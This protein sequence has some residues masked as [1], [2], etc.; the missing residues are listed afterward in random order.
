MKI[1]PHKLLILMPFVA[2]SAVAVEPPPLANNPFD[3][4]PSEVV[5]SSAAPASVPG[6]QGRPLDLRSTLV[7]AGIML[8]DVGGRVLAPGDSLGDF[9]LIRV[10]EDRAVFLYHNKPLTV[11]VR[12]APDET[13]D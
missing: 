10:Y 9:R 2:L 8:A 11:F 4:P 5:A 7:G 13:D 12:Q 6:S 3:R 1:S